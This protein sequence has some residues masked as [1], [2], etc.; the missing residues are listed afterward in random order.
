MVSVFKRFYTLHATLFASPRRNFSSNS[1]ILIQMVMW[2]FRDALEELELRHQFDDSML[3]SETGLC[4]GDVCF[5]E[6]QTTIKMRSVRL[7]TF[8][9]Y[10][11]DGAFNPDHLAP[12]HCS[13]MTT[14]LIAFLPGRHLQDIE[15]VGI[16][17]VIHRS[18]A[19]V[20]DALSVGTAL[21]SIWSVLKSEGDKQRPHRWAYMML[22][23]NYGGHM[24]FATE[25]PYCVAYA[26]E[27]WDKDPSRMTSRDPENHWYVTVS[28]KIIVRQLL[29]VLNW[30]PLERKRIKGGCLLIPR[31]VQYGPRL[32]PELV[33]PCNH[34]GPPINPAMGQDADRWVLLR[35]GSHFSRFP[36]RFGIVHCQGSNP[37]KGVGDSDPSAHA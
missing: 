15:N 4:L 31:G 20:G 9:H 7:S 22:I 2:S 26:A 8:L 16:G 3:K 5:A 17:C 32:F 24:A 1:S 6:L 23:A 30:D 27:Y 14:I 29:S 12:H 10:V 25:P 18:G 19:P 37:I 11:E 13:Q 36:R 35:C 21:K 28:E 34:A 33:V